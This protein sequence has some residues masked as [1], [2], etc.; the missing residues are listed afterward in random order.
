MLFTPHRRRRTD[1]LSVLLPIDSAMEPRFPRGFCCFI[2]F[3]V[4]VKSKMDKLVAAY[5]LNE[6]HK[7]YKIG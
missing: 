4:K 3:G 5:P 7:S 6:Y 2:C 1:P